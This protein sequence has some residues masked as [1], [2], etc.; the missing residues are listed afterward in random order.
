MDG[1]KLDPTGQ[2]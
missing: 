2:Y 1:G